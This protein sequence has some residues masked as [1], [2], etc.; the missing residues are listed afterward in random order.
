MLFLVAFTHGVAPSSAQN[1]I[2]TF[3]KSSF[4][5]PFSL[6]DPLSVQFRGEGAPLP[7]YAGH[8]KLSSA[9]SLQR[10]NVP[11]GRGVVPLCYWRDGMVGRALPIVCGG[12]VSDGRG[13]GIAFFIP[14]TW[15]GT[16]MVK[17]FQSFWAALFPFFFGS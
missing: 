5:I 11:C 10:F 1:S 13:R 6:H 4:K 9:H 14:F 17:M 2:Q 8:G 12:L 3:G 7:H 15:N 16:S